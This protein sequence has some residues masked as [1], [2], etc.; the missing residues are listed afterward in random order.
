MSVPAHHHTT[1]PQEKQRRQ[2]YD[3][4]FELMQREEE[5]KKVR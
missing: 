1:V 5:N 2:S 3:V 4:E